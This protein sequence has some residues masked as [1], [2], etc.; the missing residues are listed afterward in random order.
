MKNRDL[1]IIRKCVPKPEGRIT[2]EELEQTSLGSV[3]GMMAKTDQNR[4]FHA[5][6]DVYTHTR[7]VTEELVS[8]REY[9]EL[10]EWGRTVLFLAAL[11]HDIGKIRCTR[12]IDGKLASPNHAKKGAVRCRE[13]LFRELGL[14]GDPDLRS[15]RESV[16]A[17]IKYHSFPP[18][19]MKET[20]PEY[21]TLKIA[22]VGEL[23]PEFSLRR[24]CLLERADARGRVGLSTDDY[25]ER[26]EYCRLFAED[27]GVLDAPYT[28]SSDHTKRAYFQRKTEWKDD[29]LYN[30]SFGEVILMSGLAGTGK[31]TW[32]KKNYPDL[33]MISLDDIR[34]EFGI[35]PIGNQSEV[36]RIAHERARR[37]LREKQPFV[38]NATSV[39]ADI[40]N[41]QI[42]LFEQYGASVK[43]VFL[44]TDW[45]EGLRRNE[46]R[47]RV[48]P[49]AS[50][51]KML[52]KLEI[53]ERFESERVIWEIT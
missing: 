33:P 20:N 30:D 13:F 8:D 17:L 6:G 22:S 45:N 9:A 31:D 16:C 21:K 29:A 11:L 38:F 36:A 32:I 12:L 48:V 53:P 18:Y 50:I 42:S 28:F 52:S 14:A 1:E 43:T 7:M 19:A 49:T 35:S 25:L 10:D 3:F 15:L 51:E 4:E 26:I 37:F 40:R 46:G 34:A 24:L 2:W 5:E 39:T 41:L 44:E 47:E 27:I 23:A